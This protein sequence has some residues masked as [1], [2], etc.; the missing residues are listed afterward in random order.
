M[1]SE[2][3]PRGA[4][5]ARHIKL[6]PGG[7]SDVEWTV[8]LLQMQHAHLLPQLRTTATLP[9]L[10]AELAEALLDPADAQVL[11][12]AWQMAT[13]IRNAVMLATGRPSD[14]IPKDPKT[15][16]TVAYLMGY[17][18]SGSQQLIEDYRRG[19][20]RCRKVAERL[21]YGE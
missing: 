19:A 8:Q 12:E 13:R 5:P 6:G 16:A 18:A 2:R 21:F 9:A 10:R 7:L 17:R 11:T 14:L 1:E 4:D 20:R 15:L 3:L